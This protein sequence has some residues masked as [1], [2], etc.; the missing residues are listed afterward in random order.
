MAI[1][2][3]WAGG[4]VTGSKNLWKFTDDG[5]GLT[6]TDSLLVGTGTNVNALAV[7]LGGNL[8]VG[9]S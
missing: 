4:E 7:D 5:T 3:F 1:A 6:L 8:Y 2:A 9:T